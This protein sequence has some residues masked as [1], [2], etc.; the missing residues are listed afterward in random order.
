MH[1][2][3]H[4]TRGHVM[5]TQTIHPVH[6]FSP[7]SVGLSIAALGVAVGAGFGVAALTLDQA[8]VSPPA[9]V[10]V[11][12]PGAQPGSDAY[13]GTNRE[14]RELMHRRCATQAGC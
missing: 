9:S 11:N 14:V 10:V 5:T 4:P 8:T 2:I 3:H 12:A 1:D 6:R 7:K 13:D